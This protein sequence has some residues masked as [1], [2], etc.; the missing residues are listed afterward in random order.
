MMK[1]RITDF[2][3]DDELVSPSQ[4]DYYDYYVPE[5]K[6]VV[7]P[8]H[9]TAFAFRFAAMNYQLQHRV[10]YQYKLE[11]YNNEWCNADKKRMAS[12]ADI[13]TGT[14]RFRVRAF[15]LESP[16]KYDMRTIEVVVPPSFILAG[17]SVWLYMLLI[18]CTSLGLMFWRQQQLQMKYETRE[19]KD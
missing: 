7:L 15:L 18:L 6:Q 17:S 16:E 3:I 4:N 5:A 14:Y 9:S 11:G 12:Y 19:L 2:F 10:H 13:P 8:S 1:L